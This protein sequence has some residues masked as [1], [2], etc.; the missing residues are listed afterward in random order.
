MAGENGENGPQI[1]HTHAL[2]RSAFR[3][4][5]DFLLKLWGFGILSGV[6]GLQFSSTGV[7]LEPTFQ[8]ARYMPTA[9]LYAYLYAYLYVCLDMRTDMHTHEVARSGNRNYGNCDLILICREQR[10]QRVLRPL[11]QC[12]VMLTA[13]ARCART[14]ST[15]T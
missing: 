14:M 11:R 4:R 2:A 12:A 8:R 13:M 7:P 9:C 5:N 1:T 3:S 6:L 15:A 10:T